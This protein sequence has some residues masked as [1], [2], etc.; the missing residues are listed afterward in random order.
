MKHPTS[1]LS[2]EDLLAALERFVDAGELPDVL[3]RD[4]SIFIICR[5]RFFDWLGCQQVEDGFCLLESSERKHSDSLE[6]NAIPG[7]RSIPEFD[8]FPIVG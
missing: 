5:I 6:L 2:H 8:F 7:H 1:N 4:G 3:G